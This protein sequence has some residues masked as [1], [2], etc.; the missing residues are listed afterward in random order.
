VDQDTKDFLIS[1]VAALVIA[2]LLIALVVGCEV[3]YT[4]AW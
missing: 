2:G 1:V 4:G 3:Y